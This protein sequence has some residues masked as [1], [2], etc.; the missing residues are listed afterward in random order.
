M[1]RIVMLLTIYTMT[2]SLYAGTF[3][4]GGEA[5][6][7]T[8]IGT[9]KGYWDW[10]DKTEE[11][12]RNPFVFNGGGSLLM[13]V[14]IH[15]LFQL[16]TGVSYFVN[17]CRIE[18]DGVN[19]IYRQDTLDIPLGVRMFFKRGK[20]GVYVKGAAVLMILMDNASFTDED[21]NDDLFSSSVPGQRYHAGLQAGMG[22]QQEA[23][24]GIWQL[25]ARYANFYTSPDYER[26]DGTIGDV[27]FHRI[28]LAFGW[29][30]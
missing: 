25:E 11:T 3:H 26:E 4:F 28:Q 20:R 9:G 13:L 10:T 17:R 23:K 19:R 14:D 5:A 27:R 29:F 2:V 6:L 8:A 15:P 21:G 16:E 1:K 18:N 30:Y 12:L 22:F 24:F 7:G